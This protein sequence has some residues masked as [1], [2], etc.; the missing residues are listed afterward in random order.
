LELDSD[1]PG[2]ASHYAG[3]KELRERDSEVQE[4]FVKAWERAKDTGGWKLEAG[5]GVLPFAELKTALVPDFTLKNESGETVHLEILGF[6]SERNLIERVALLRE[7]R[8]RGHRL[9]IA[10][11]ENLGT[12][13]EALQEAAKGEVIPFKNRLPVKAVV[14]KLADALQAPER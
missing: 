14:E 3:P 1:S 2:L 6:W 12:S 13:P 8:D 5:A 4:A 7:A 11:S 10:A 9:L